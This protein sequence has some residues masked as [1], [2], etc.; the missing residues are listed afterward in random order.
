M[1]KSNETKHLK[2]V[3]K[4]LKKGNALELASNN[5][6]LLSELI[7]E[8]GKPGFAEM[9]AA[10]WKAFTAFIKDEFNLQV[11]SFEVQY[12]QEVY[13]FTLLFAK[14]GETDGCPL[15]VTAINQSYGFPLEFFPRIF[16]I[17]LVATLNSFPMESV[18]AFAFAN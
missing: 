15:N 10:K 18:A 12:A 14:R 13:V 7:S 9:A 4:T 8:N 11:N 5:F 6:Q 3:R 16:A 1:T 17:Q 2:S